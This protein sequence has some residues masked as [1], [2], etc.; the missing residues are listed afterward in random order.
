MCVC[1]ASLICRTATCVQLPKTRWVIRSHVYCSVPRECSLLSSLAHSFKSTF[2]P[3]IRP[4]H[5]FHWLFR[6]FSDIL[7]VLSL[8]DYHNTLNLQ[9][10][11]LYLT[12]TCISLSL[13]LS[14]FLS[15]FLSFSQRGCGDIGVCGEVDSERHDRS[16][17]WRETQGK[18]HHCSSEGKGMFAYV[19]VEK[20]GRDSTADGFSF[21]TQGGTGFAGSGVQLKAK[22]ARPVMQA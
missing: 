22:E 8:N 1:L 19:Q 12:H 16:D 21:L 7:S 3:L 5:Y 4:T 20:D 18:R 17:Q 14:F 6:R 10:Y 9:G 13:S 11:M 15:F 2:R